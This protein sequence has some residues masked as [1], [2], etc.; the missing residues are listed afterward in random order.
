MVSKQNEQL[1]N[2]KR[3]LMPDFHLQNYVMLCK[4]VLSIYC[5][6][7]GDLVPVETPAAI[8]ASS[9]QNVIN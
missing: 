3:L 9:F 7:D 8:P 1:L 4:S 5:P 2:E 6:G